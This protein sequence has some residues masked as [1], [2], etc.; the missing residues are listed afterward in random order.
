MEGNERRFAKEIRRNVSG[1]REDFIEPGEWGRLLSLE[2]RLA[3]W[4]IPLEPGKK[5]LEIGS[6]T[7]IFLD[8]MR[9]KGIDAVGIDARPRGKGG[10]PHAAARIEQLPFP[11]RSFD[12][13]CHTKAN[14]APPAKRLVH[15]SLDWHVNGRISTHKRVA[16][17][18][19]NPP[20]KTWTE[21][22]HALCVVTQDGSLR[23][24]S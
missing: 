8:Q 21:A 23:T 14:N 20:R 5:V 22:T 11:D 3:A 16:R 6:A 18:M 4:G 12:F 10:A 24:G 1:V 2:R 7:G 19:A 17:T 9:E 15:P 13:V